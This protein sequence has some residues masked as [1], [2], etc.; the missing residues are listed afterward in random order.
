MYWSTRGFGIYFTQDWH[1]E[2]NYECFMM[3]KDAVE[4]NELRIRIKRVILKCNSSTGLPSAPGRPWLLLRLSSAALR[5]QTIYSLW[6][7]E[8][9]GCPEKQKGNDE[10]LKTFLWLKVS[11]TRD[12]KRR[13][14]LRWTIKQSFI[15]V[16]VFLLSESADT[17]TA[18]ITPVWSSDVSFCPFFIRKLSY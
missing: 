18:V 16:L 13:F 9:L 11:T 8:L 10:A 17:V 4:L 15:T 14:L 2:Q 5:S 12:R 6:F 7:W 3:P 1:L